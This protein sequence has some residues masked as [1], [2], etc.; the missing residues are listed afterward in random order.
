MSKEAPLRFL[1][2]GPNR[3]P[4]L[5]RPESFKNI[6]PDQEKVS[7]FALE[8]IPL[9]TQARK[10]EGFMYGS[11][12]HM[13]FPPN[14]LDLIVAK[15]VFGAQYSSEKEPLSLVAARK[16]TIIP[17][18]ARTLKP[19]GSMIVIESFT[20][21]YF[22]ESIMLLMDGS[23]V[24]EKSM[25]LYL[26]GK[27]ETER[28]E[29]NSLFDK[30]HHLLESFDSL[31]TTSYDL[32]ARLGENAGLR[33][34][35]LIGKNALVFIRSAKIPKRQLYFQTEYINANL[36]VLTLEKPQQLSPGVI[37]EN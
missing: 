27:T 14:S 37:E 5:K 4:I 30:A 22:Y 1:E 24:D 23:M 2:I 21:L 32:I 31:I 36:F 10:V 26:A 6:Y 3:Y 13:P 7:K 25:Q 35:T 11:A 9:P 20:P 15:D 29:L 12:S 34:N 8:T 18:A 19:G 28:K 17:E 33:T 16:C